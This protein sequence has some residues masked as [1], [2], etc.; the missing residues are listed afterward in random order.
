MHFGWAL[1]LF[2]TFVEAGRD[3]YKILGV[4]RNANT[5]QI[6]KAYRKLAKELHPDRNKD[7]PIS[8]EKFQD[9]GAAYEVLSDSKKRKVYD[10]QGEEGVKNMGDGG[11]GRG[12]HEPFSSFFGDFFGGGH[13]ESDE[14]PKGADVVIDLYATLDEVYNG[15]FVAI[16]R[17]KSVYKQT[18]GTREC[19][20]RHEMRAQQLGGGHLQMF[21]VRVCDECPNVKLIQETKHLEVEIEIGADDGHEQRFSGEGE[22]HVDGEP[23]DLVVR[24]KIHKHNVFERR[25]LDLYTNVTISLQQALSG[26]EMDIT[27]LDGHKVH[28]SREKV[29]WP[30]ARIRK[31]DEGMPS[32]EDNNRKGIL[33]ITFDV[34]FPQ[35]QFNEEQ[36]KLIA[37]LLQQSEHKPKIYNG[38][39]G[40]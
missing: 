31:K 5:N 6:K 16:K 13:E 2:L 12:G 15:N 4:P 40:F 10:R 29:T 34:E 32:L 9:L 14:V 33:Y 18:S 26:F 1:I 36:Q 8:Q 21:Q 28:V 27:H 22:P 17:K 25:G 24:L 11:F 37:E 7:D 3:F 30:G 35:G 19:N 20:C 23:G 39:Q 38:L